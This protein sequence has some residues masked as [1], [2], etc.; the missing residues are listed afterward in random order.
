MKARLLLVS[1]SSLLI[2]DMRRRIT[3]ANFNL[4]KS[5]ANYDEFNETVDNFK[6]HCV[7][8]MLS[9]ENVETLS[10]FS[11]IEENPYYKNLPLL[12]VGSSSDCEMFV[13]RVKHERLFTILRPVDD[14]K[15]SA[16]LKSA[17]EYADELAD[18]SE[19][20]PEEQP[21][22][23]ESG[24]DLLKS[25]MAEM[26]DIKPKDTRKH[27]LVVDDDT[28]MLNLIKSYLDDIY[29]V[30]IVTSG[31]QALR[32]LTKKPCD[33]ILLDYVMPDDPGPVVLHK[34]RQAFTGEQLPVIFLTGVSDKDAILT[35]MRQNPQD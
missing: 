25:L 28:F 16:V 17:T 10:V 3:S 20:I 12:I 11:L 2:D 35:G 21:P 30:S 15:L 34:I 14:D 33:L 9:H 6:P 5:Y 31:N 29:D 23:D 22:L 24:S 27:I 19:T 4:R 1:R 18:D 8:V 32:F 7:V 26:G 13:N